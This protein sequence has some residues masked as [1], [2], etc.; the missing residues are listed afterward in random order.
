VTNLNFDKFKE[1]AREIL[2][3]GINNT[4]KFMELMQQRGWPVKVVLPAAMHL[5]LHGKLD[6]NGNTTPYKSN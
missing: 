5:L 4:G 2:D 3:A 1:D 6:P